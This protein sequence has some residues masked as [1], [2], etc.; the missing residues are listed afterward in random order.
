MAD[1]DKDDLERALA[2]LVEVTEKSGNLRNDL[3]K[4]I[5]EAVSSLRNYFMQV[6]TELEAKTAAHKKKLEREA[7][8]SRKEIQRVPRSTRWDKWY[9]LLTK[10]DT[11]TE[12][13]DSRCHLKGTLANFT[14]R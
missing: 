5:L 6:Q 2:R 12:V 14:P 13:L 10:Y 3:R 7:R 11:S 4:D 8:E 9:Q 1:D